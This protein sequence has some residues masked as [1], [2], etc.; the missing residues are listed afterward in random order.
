[1]ST[2]EPLLNICIP[3]KNASEFFKEA[4]MSICNQDYKNWMIYILNDGSKQEEA[5]KMR[6]ILSECTSKYKIISDRDIG[7]YNARLRLMESIKC[8]YIMFLD[9]DDRYLSRDV[10]SQIVKCIASRDPDVLIYD[11]SLKENAVKPVLSGVAKLKG[12]EEIR[13]EFLITNRLN[14]L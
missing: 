2:K 7:I 10:F 1:M 3:Y 6:D 14:S 8:G 9:A 13:K 12:I 5:Q 11:Y 4:I